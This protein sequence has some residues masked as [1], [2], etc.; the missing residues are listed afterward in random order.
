MA[1]G[2]G[3]LTLHVYAACNIGLNVGRGFPEEQCRGQ[4]YHRLQKYHSLFID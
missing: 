2:K 3:L 4:K 1:G